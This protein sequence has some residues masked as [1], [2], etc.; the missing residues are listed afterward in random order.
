[1]NDLVYIRLREL[2]WQRKLTEAEEAELQK[3]L[4]GHPE[5]KADW[6]AEAEL[7]QLLDGLP[8]APPVASNFT[9]LVL[10]AAARES[11][12]RARN[13]GWFAWPLRN[14][15]PKTAAACL[16]LSLG[17]FGYQ[18]HRISART[19]M[20]RKVARLAGA[21]SASPELL[22]NYDRIRRLSDTPPKA[23]AD[24]LVLLK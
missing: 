9:A 18:Q 20:A 11:T 1:M 13:S 24:L 8:D 22:D 14:W 3:H 23:D 15:L 17:F 7:N 10:Q 4:A 6:E 19:A 21:I 5:A 16:L 2:S 12:A